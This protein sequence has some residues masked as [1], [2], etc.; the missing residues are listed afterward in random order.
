MATTAHISD[1]LRISVP[2]PLRRGR[3][4][5]W[6]CRDAYALA[7]QHTRV[8]PA[9]LRRRL[10]IPTAKGERC[11]DELEREGIVGARSPGGS[12][13]VLVHGKAA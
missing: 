5:R 7:V 1:L 13:E 3:R 11:L 10:R 9:M 4:L 8:S 12:R 2:L 6:P